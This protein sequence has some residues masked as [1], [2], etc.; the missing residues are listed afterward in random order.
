MNAISIDLEDWFCAYN[1]KINIEDWDKCE[2]RL[3]ESTNRIMKILDKHNVKAT[4]FV[5]G[6]VAECVPVLVREIESQGHEIAAHGYSH[7]LIT[8]MTSQE[9]DEDIR[10]A[11]YS[12]NACV[13][14]PV[15]GYRAPSFTITRKTL[16]AIEILKKYGIKYDSSVFPVGFHPDYGIADSPLDIH[17]LMGLIEVPLSVAEVLGKRIPCSGGGYFRLF[18]YMITKK[19]MKKC[20]KQGRPVIFY[21]HPWETDTGQPRKKMPLLNRFRH[22]NNLGKTVI[23]LDKLLSDFEFVTIKRILGL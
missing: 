14:S 12:I 7:R 23:R 17:E 1:L 22:Y 13:S 3:V 11:L 6:W 5:L 2:F 9:F 20:N 8:D 16:W 15:I 19:L 4:F 18:P 21:L 10:K